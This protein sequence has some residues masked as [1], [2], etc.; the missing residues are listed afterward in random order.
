MEHN[1]QLRLQEQ[2]YFIGL[3]LWREIAQ[4]MDSDKFTMRMSVIWLCK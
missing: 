1:L 4:T 3:K 2:I